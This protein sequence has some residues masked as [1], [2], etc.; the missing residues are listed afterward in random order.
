MG[1]GGFCSFSKLNEQEKLI[2]F[3]AIREGTK[4]ESEAE[5]PLFRAN[6]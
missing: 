6:Y 1:N 3:Q 2:L 5:V 4:A